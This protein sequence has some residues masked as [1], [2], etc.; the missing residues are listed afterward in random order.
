MTLFWAKKH[1]IWYTIS[2]KEVKTMANNP[3]NTKIFDRAT[4]FALQAHKNTERRGKAYPYIIHPMEAASIVATITNDQEILAA[5]I[6][7]DVIEDC[8]KTVDEIKEEFGERVAELVSAES[9]VQFPGLSETQSWKA[10]KQYAIDNLKS[11]SHDAKIV[12]LGDKLSNMR[13]I[14]RDYKEQ[15]EKLWDL[16]HAPDPSLHKW[17][18]EGLRDALSELSDT[19]AFQEFDRLIKET[20]GE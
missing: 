2:R 15:G 20:F 19:E 17:H 3:L 6:L 9:D 10:R 5:A 18:Y 13:G 14:A 1:I 8:G 4:L 12:A 16:F 7:H 11:Q